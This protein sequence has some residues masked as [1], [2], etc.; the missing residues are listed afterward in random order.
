MKKRLLA[1][2]LAVMIISALGTVTAAADDT[3]MYGHCG[4]AESDNVWW[5]LA[6]NN[7]GTDTYTLTFTGTG[8][9][10]WDWRTQAQVEGGLNN[11]TEEDLPPYYSYR[12]KI[13]KV[14]VGEGITGGA[15]AACADFTALTEVSLPSTFSDMGNDMFWHCTS[16]ERIDLPASLTNI[17]NSAFEGCTALKTVTFHPDTGEIKV[18]GFKGCTSLKSIALPDKVISVGSFEGSGLTSITVDPS[19]PCTIA[20]SAFTNCTSLTSATIGKNV[21]SIGNQA[22]YNDSALETIS[23]AAR[24]IG[25]SAFGGCTKLTDVELKEGVTAISDNAFAV[26]SSGVQGELK[27]VRL[28]ST[29]TSIGKAFNQ[30]Y[31]L[32]VLD[33]SKATGLTTFSNG[34]SFAGSS[35]IYVSTSDIATALQTVLSYDGTNNRACIAVTNGG[36]FDE[37]GD[38]NLSESS[39]VN[40]SAPSKIG[41][42]FG[43]WYSNS[44]F[45]GDSVTVPVDTE[46]GSNVAY[47]VHYAKWTL[48]APT[49]TVTTDKSHIANGET[50][51]LTATAAHELD[52]V[53]Y[54]YQW[55]TGTPDSGNAIDGATNA[56][57]T[58]SNLSTATSYY[59]KVTAVNGSDE[60]EAVSDAVTVNPSKN[61]G[62]VTITYPAEDTKT[63]NLGDRPFDVIYTVSGDRAA[64][65]ISS[66]PSVATVSGNTVTIVGVGTAEIT[67]NFAGDAE[68]STA[69][70]SFTL[71]VKPADKPVNIPD[72]YDIDLIVSDG[73]SAKTN[74]SNASAGTVITV[75]AT[76]DEGY[77]LDYITVDGERISGTSFKMPAHD[78]TVRVYFTDGTSTLPF[79]DVRPNQWFYDAVAYVYTNGMMEGDSATTFNPDGQMTR[80]MVWSI[81]ARID[82]ETVTGANWIDTARVW[83]M[84]EG[85]SD[86][87]DPTGLVTREQLATMLWRYAGEPAST[88][89]LAAYADASSVSDYAL[90]RNALGCRKR[91]NL[92]RERNDA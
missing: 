11:A 5:S 18:N 58:V 91:H 44:D 77:E 41:Y 47:S 61:P 53:T 75:T 19:V 89:G 74:L 36:V 66:N 15:R 68:Y 57:Y 23:I 24:S 60:S 25:Q 80:A 9:I 35:I 38:F 34:L 27:V 49:V 76:P 29:V 69:S 40:F 52:S 72:T 3:P 45:T 32:Q 78:V 16:L 62:S 51:T 59:C 85:V 14:V 31:K 21:T 70:D 30:T 82:G 63:V 71:V 73:G 12:E 10:T 37:D 1:V 4:N 13:T 7:D 79:T 6:R 46:S 22:F 87:T 84:S 83:A 56:T 28:P 65:L 43:G 17:G 88:Y 33:M 48:D 8:N 81:L 42:T 67:V 26:N 64:T 55:Y 20:N 86:G 50:A 54:E 90:D 2:L 92:R 39:P